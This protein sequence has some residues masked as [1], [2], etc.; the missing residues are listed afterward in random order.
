MRLVLG[1]LVRTRTRWLVVFDNVVDERVVERFWPGVGRG[2]GRGSVIVTSR[3]RGVVK[4]MKG[5]EIEVGGMGGEEASHLLL[6]CLGM[7]KTKVDEK[8]KAAARQLSE[9]LSGLPLAITQ[10]AA[11]IKERKCTI[12]GFLEEYRKQPEALHREK[13][14]KK[15]DHDGYGHTLDTVWNVSFA[16]LDKDSPACLGILSF[17]APDAIPVELFVEDEDVKVGARLDFCKSSL[18]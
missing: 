18:R 13:Q 8:E 14:E 15:W 3:R 1:W 16:A 11:L 2:R 10:M 17:L 6:S 4:G 9:E 12:G 7:E 5:K